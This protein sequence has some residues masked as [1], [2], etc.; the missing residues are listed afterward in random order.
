MRWHYPYPKC[1]G[2][3]TYNSALVR[4]ALLNWA[5]LRID[6]AIPLAEAF[7]HLTRRLLVRTGALTTFPPLLARLALPILPAAAARR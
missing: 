3:L 6:D 5:K 1:D 7:L 2:A 4:L